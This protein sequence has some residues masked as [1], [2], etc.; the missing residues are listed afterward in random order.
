MH[1]A[2]ACAALV[3]VGAVQETHVLAERATAP[4]DVALR[5]RDE[6][7]ASSPLRVVH[8]GK[9]VLARYAVALD[10]KPAAAAVTCSA[11]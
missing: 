2:R 8:G 6:V 10:A 4:R 7:V 1:A 5:R 3:R 11:L 9:G